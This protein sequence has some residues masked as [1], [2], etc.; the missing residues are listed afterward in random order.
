MLLFTIMLHLHRNK[1]QAQGCIYIGTNLELKHNF[2]VVC[3]RGAAAKIKENFRFHQIEL[4]H[5]T[6]ISPRSRP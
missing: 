1:H 6:E 4:D 2:S 5:N 3:L